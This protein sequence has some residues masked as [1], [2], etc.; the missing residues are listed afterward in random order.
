MIRLSYV[1]VCVCV[2]M[3]LLQDDLVIDVAGMAI[4]NGWFDPVSQVRFFALFYRVINL[5][6]AMKYL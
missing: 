6:A 3:W 1:C 2:C 5:A 4:G